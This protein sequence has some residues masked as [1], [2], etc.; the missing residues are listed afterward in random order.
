[1]KWYQIAGEQ[2]MVEFINKEICK[3]F[4]YGELFLLTN[5]LKEAKEKIAQL[6]NTVAELEI[7]VPIEGGKE[8][9]A[10]KARFDELKANK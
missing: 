8:Y 2:D 9:Q 6:E 5:E 10:N 7:T 1:M 3:S 4:T